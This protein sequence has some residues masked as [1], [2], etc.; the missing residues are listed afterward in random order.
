MNA[1][2]PLSPDHSADLKADPSADLSPPHGGMSDADLHGREPAGRAQA[3]MD[4]RRDYRWTPV[5]QRAFLMEIACTGSVTRAAR[6]VNKT[7]RSAYDLRHR[8]DGAAFALGWDAA[9]QVARVALADMLM[10]R[11]ISGYDESYI[12]KDDGTVVRSKYDNRLGIGLLNRLDRMAESHATRPGRDAQIALIAQDF[13][14]FLDM[15]AR[16]GT[17]A[18]AALFFAARGDV[19]WHDKQGKL[20][21]GIPHAIQCE[22]AQNSA[23]FAGDAAA[24]IDPETQVAQMRVWFDAARDCWCTNFPPPVADQD[25][26]AGQEDDEDEIDDD[27]IYDDEFDIDIDD[28]GDVTEFG[29]FG[30]PS[31]FR[32]LSPAEV[33]AQQARMC[34][35]MAPLYVAAQA[36]RADWFA[37]GATGV[38]AADSG[39]MN[40]A[41][42][43]EENAVPRW[44]NSAR[45]RTN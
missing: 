22:L 13:E 30:S 19:P 28:E 43:R 40:A 26:L 9:M 24:E 16:G 15:I 45:L 4:I 44:P 38:P 32:T 21:A 25:P 18:E 31:Y 12:R 35:Q 1:Y 10:D 20:S 6:Y 23:D 34:A 3:M 8:R 14:N 42:S 11:A 2:S 36:A 27:D 41:N 37:G 29:H 39:D 7:P 17:G 5:C 33:A